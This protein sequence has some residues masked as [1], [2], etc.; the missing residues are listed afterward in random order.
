MH[1]T[2]VALSAALR[3]LNSLV[4]LLVRIHYPF[5]ERAATRFISIHIVKSFRDKKIRSPIREK[6]TLQQ[7]EIALNNH[8]QRVLHQIVK[9]T[10]PLVSGERMSIRTTPKVHIEKSTLFASRRMR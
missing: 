10:V 5:Q 3:L 8:M 2:H 1:L 7:L 4:V 6:G 9:K